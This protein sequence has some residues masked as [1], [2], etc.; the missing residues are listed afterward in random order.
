MFVPGDSEKKITK[1]SL[2]DA[3][4]LI[5]CLEDAVAESRKAVARTLVSQHLQAH[6][7]DSTSQLWVRINAIETKHL[8]A[9]LKTVMA[10]AP[11]GIFLPKPNCA[12]DIE[13]LDHYLSAFETQHN[14]PIGKTRIMT[15]VESARGSL[16]QSTFADASPRFSSM[17]WGAEDISADIGASCNKDEAGAHF[18]IH[19]MHRAQCLLVCAAANL[20]AVDGI[21]SDFL[22][23]TNLRQQCMRARQEGFSGKIAIHPSQ[24]TV[25][26]ECFTPSQDEID[27]AQRVCQAFAQ[28]DTGTV[29][30]D[31]KML[32]LPHLKQAKKIIQQTSSKTSIT[33]Q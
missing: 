28:A 2:L 19:Q 5:F 17:T 10:A 24:I 25:I 26:N 33:Q 9:D 14:I 29:A 22:D 30:L 4:A 16:N 15:V 23:E 12:K 6:R 8:L 18:L 3:D 31:G 20:Q 32:D 11:H 27:Y 1:S 21:C 7:R 13:T